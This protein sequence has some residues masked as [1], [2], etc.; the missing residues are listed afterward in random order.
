M[1]MRQVETGKRGR[2]PPH[3]VAPIT[4]QDLQEVAAI[5]GA[6]VE[7]S[8]LPMRAN[9][10]R[11]TPPLHFAWASSWRISLLRPHPEADHLNCHQRRREASA[12]RSAPGL[13]AL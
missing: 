2:R 8:G 3:Q 12:W 9:P 7:A 13:A 1:T 6:K 5:A 11:Q 4:D 10:Y